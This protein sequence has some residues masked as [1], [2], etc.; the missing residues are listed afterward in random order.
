M[1]MYLYSLAFMDD[2]CTLGAAVCHHA[3]PCPLYTQPKARQV[4]SENLS[5]PEQDSNP[6]Y[7]AWK[8][9]ALTTRPPSPH[10][11]GIV[12]YIYLY[13]WA[14]VL[15]FWI[16]NWIFNFWK[17]LIKATCWQDYT[18]PVLAD[19]LTHC[20]RETCKRVTGKQC[21]PRS[22]ATEC[23]IWSGSPLFATSIAIFL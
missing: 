4:W 8:S 10:K 12:V 2:L 19:T 18:A 15:P 9:S 20:S 13:L 5:R 17:T 16:F 1:Y 21:R 11:Q 22:E 23:G 3:P 14:R 7:L 6:W